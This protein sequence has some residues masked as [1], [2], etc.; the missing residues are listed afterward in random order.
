MADNEGS[1][2]TYKPNSAAAMIFLISFTLATLWHIVIIFR[3]RVRYFIVLAI[4]GALEIAGYTTRFLATRDTENL[5]FF[6]VQT[7]CILVAPAL[8]AA[9]IYVV[10]GRLILLLGGE[11]YS[12][13]KPSRLTLIFVGGDVVTFLVQVMG[14]G[15]LRTNFTLGKTIILVGLGAQIVFFALFIALASVFHRRLSSK[16]TD[17]S[18]SM[19]ARNGTKSWRGVMLVLYVSSALIFIRSVFRLIEFTGNR[20]SLLHKSEAFLYVCDSLLMLGVLAVLIYN[21]PS[22]YVPGWR[23]IKQMQEAEEMM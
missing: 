9:S 21:H 15:M 19:D 1:P 5:T 4:G 18:L 7:L 6:I 20:D 8:F 3:R 10:L 14:S 2:W 11:A 17:Q 22:E 13:V 23:A 16:P 12:P